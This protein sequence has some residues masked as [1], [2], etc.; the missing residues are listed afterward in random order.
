MPFLKW[1]RIITLQ[2]VKQ[3]LEG[4]W[5]PSGARDSISWVPVQCSLYDLL[6]SMHFAP[7][8]TQTINATRPEGNEVGPVW[9]TAKQQRTAAQDWEHTRRNQELQKQLVFWD[10]SWDLSKAAGVSEVYNLQRTRPLSHTLVSPTLLIVYRF[11]SPYSSRH[12]SALY[13]EVRHLPGRWI[14]GVWFLGL[15]PYAP[16]KKHLWKYVEVGYNKTTFF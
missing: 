11:S 13:S 2:L 4:N 8:G 7:G 10:Q 5:M 6:H 3:I 14:K 16:R 15:H 1:G 9:C 12:F